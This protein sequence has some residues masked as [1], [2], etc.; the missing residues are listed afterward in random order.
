MARKA[1]LIAGPTASGKSAFGLTRARETGGVIVNA[2]SMQVYDVLRV[3]TARPSVDDLARA[4]HRLY[5]FVAPETRCSVGSWLAAVDAV[6]SD[7]ALEGRELIFVGGTGLYFDALENGIADI[8]DVPTEAIA[9][10]EALVLPLDRDE[11]IG[12]LKA[13]DPEMAATLGEPDPQRLIRALSVL[14]G[15]GRSL[16][17]WQT[18]V[19]PPL[20]DGFD[21]DRIVIEIDKTK[22]SERIEARFR[23]MLDMGAIDEVTDL[24]GLALA[25]DLPVMKAIGVREIAVWQ[26][27]AI[28]KE[29][30]IARA[31][32]ATRQYAKRQRTWF[33]QRMRSWRWISSPEW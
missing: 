21:V 24:M 8:P 9:E 29:E 16:A 6:I 14:I 20:L 4:D 13:R 18:R 1:I 7:S 10:A 2:D 25:P 30:A 3:L 17:F 22:L 28:S 26:S 11:R 33:R 27:G 12:L 15:T 23:A 5:G 32:I 19:S 31:V